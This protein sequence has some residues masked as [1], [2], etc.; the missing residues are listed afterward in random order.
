MQDRY[1]GTVFAPDLVFPELG[2]RQKTALLQRIA[3][4]AFRDQGLSAQSVDHE[5]IREKPEPGERRLI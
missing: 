3:L 4:A 1:A 5:K 2:D